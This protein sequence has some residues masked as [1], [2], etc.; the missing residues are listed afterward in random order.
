VWQIIGQKNAVSLLQRSLE[1]GSLAHAYLFTGPAHAGKMTLAVKLAQALNCE[2]EEPPCGQCD[3][4]Q[5][6][7][8]G[9]HADVQIISLAGDDSSESKS[10]T[11]IGIDRIRQVQHSANLPPFEGRYKVFIIDEA[12]FLSIEAAN[13]LLKTLEEPEAKMVFVLLTTD[14]SLLPVTVVSRCQPVELVPVPAKEIEDAL[15]GNWGVETQKAAQLARLSRGCFGWA[16]SAV[17]DDNLLQ[18]RAEWLDALIDIVDADYEERFAYS[19]QLASRFSQSRGPVYE[20]LKLWLDWWRDLL[21][22]KAGRAGDVT[23]AD[24]IDELEKMAKNRSLAQIRAFI[25]SIQEAGEQLRQNANPRLVLEVLMLSIPGA[26]R[27][28][29]AVL[30]NLR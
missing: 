30:P 16:V 17:L 15:I 21:L 20:Q 24:R 29:E 10:R 14:K 6:I 9:K 13:A 11:E 3:S 2:G 1:K 23:N 26:G 7:A 8:S 22:V 4:C 5:K 27:G 25:G 12:G 28:Q 19:T 18:Q